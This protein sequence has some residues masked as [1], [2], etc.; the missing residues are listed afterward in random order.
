VAGQIDVAQIEGLDQGGEIGGEGV[1]VVPD[2]RLAGLAETPPV[3]RDHPKT[4]GE[5]RPLLPLPSSPAQRK[6]VDE[7]DRL[8][9]SVVL[10]VELD[11]N[12][13]LAPDGDVGH[14]GSFPRRS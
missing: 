1:V 4:G 9:G 10:V 6:P 2:R 11:V 13:V 7:H 14:A 8:T 5:Q 3:V 12:G